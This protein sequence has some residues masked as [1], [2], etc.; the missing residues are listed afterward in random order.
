MWLLIYF[1]DW[2]DRQTFRGNKPRI[3][4]NDWAKLEDMLTYAVMLITE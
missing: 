3:M 1:A 2:F 4:L